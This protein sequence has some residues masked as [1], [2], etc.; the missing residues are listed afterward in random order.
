MTRRKK[1]N[2]FRW[3]EQRNI[4]YQAYEFDDT[5]HSA[6]EVAETLNIPP[7]QIFKTLV[8]MSSEQKPMLVLVSA[9]C[10]LDLKKLAATLGQKKVQMASHDEAESLTGLQTGGISA[11]AL[12]AKNWPIYLDES[13]TTFEEIFMSAGRRGINVRLSRQ[14]FIDAFDVE[15]VDCCSPLE[16]DF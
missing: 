7:A 14:A 16:D 3:L 2:A 13:A 15:I 1:L 8:V 11:L 10:A 12:T 5:L 6:Q 4:S 9:Q